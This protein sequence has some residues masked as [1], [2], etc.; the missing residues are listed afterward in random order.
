MLVGLHQATAVTPLEQV[1][2]TAV[3]P[4]ERLRVGAVE[5]RHPAREIRPWR[6]EDEVIVVDHQAVGQARP[7]AEALHAPAD[8][9]ELRAIAVVLEDPVAIVPTIEHVVDPI[10]DLGA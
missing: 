10:L 7:V 4:V 3:A 8:G 1:P 6:L 2:D 9:D 5:P